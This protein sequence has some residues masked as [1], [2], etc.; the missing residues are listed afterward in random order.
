MVVLQGF[1]FSLWVE[2]VEEGVWWGVF[3]FFLF[4]TCLFLTIYLN[5]KNQTAILALKIFG[6]A[7]YIDSQLPAFGVLRIFGIIIGLAPRSG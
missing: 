3:I 7:L 1:E 6:Q 2:E 5:F 4:V